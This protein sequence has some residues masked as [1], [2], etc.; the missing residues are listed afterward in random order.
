MDALFFVTV[1][2]DEDPVQIVVFGFQSFKLQ[3]L[4]HA[5]S[6]HR[7][8]QVCFVGQD[9]KGYLS[10]FYGWVTGQVTQTLT[11]YVDAVPVS[12]VDHEE[13]CVYLWIKEGPRRSVSTLP[14]HIIHEACFSFAR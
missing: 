11:C 12:G 13:N 5:V 2:F 3:R 4:L 6:F 14:T 8:R 10:V 7:L 1:A 9:Y